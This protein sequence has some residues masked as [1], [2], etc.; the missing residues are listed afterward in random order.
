MK[1]CEHS[2]CHIIRKLPSRWSGVQDHGGEQVTRAAFVALLSLAALAA[3]A[4]VRNVRTAN[5]NFY[6][7]NR[8]AGVAKVSRPSAPTLPVVNSTAIGCHETSLA[9]P[10]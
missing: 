1:A 10:S 6:V 2:A 8:K 7:I 9:G 3:T 4:C 5:D